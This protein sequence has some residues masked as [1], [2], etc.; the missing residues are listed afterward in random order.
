MEIATVQPSELAALSDQ[1]GK[2][3]LIDVRTA[4]EFQSLHV[5][6]ALNFP[7]DQLDPAAI[8][9]ARNGSAEKQL[10]VIC[11]A[12]G[13]SRKACERFQ[14]AGFTNVVNVAGGTQAWA[15]AGLPV[16]QG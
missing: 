14:A 10:Y 11:Q 5:P 12:G 6:D 15:Q 9:Q 3:D 1:Q 8:M 7:L 13:R 16:V 4:D 2:V